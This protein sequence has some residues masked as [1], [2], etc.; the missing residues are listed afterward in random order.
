MKLLDCL[1]ESWIIPELKGRDK[2]S[3]LKELSE[4]LVHPCGLSSSKELVSAL[5]EREKLGSTGIGEGV[6]IPHGRLKK[7]KHFYI[8]F[9]RSLNGVDFDAIDNKPCQL[10]F[11]VLAPEN[12]TSEN[13]HLLARIANLLKDSSFKKRLLEA[14]SQKELFE[15]ISEEDRKY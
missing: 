2:E 15:I 14:T 1:E 11:L 9:G 6:A 3:I 5:L 12:S 7:L 13:L 8:S 10:F 4:V